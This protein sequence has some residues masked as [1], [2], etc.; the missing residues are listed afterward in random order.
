MVIRY[1][2]EHYYENI[3]IDFLASKFYVSASYFSHIFKKFAQKSL[4]EYLNEVRISHAKVLL[5]RDN[6]S[7]GEISAKVGYSD[8]NYF[9][10]RFKKEVGITAT[11]YRK[12]LVKQM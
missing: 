10:R 1:I 2:G 11:E 3:S 8:I 12:H 4:V 6:M 5:E 9:S 7:I